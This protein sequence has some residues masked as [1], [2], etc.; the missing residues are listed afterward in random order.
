M[1]PEALAQVLR[2]LPRLNSDDLLIGYDTSDDACVYRISDTQAMIQTVDFFPPMVDDPYL[3]G[4]IAAANALSDV[5]AMGGQPVLA[6]NLLCFP[7]CL[8]PTIAGQ[9][10]AGG[11]NK[12]AEAGCVIAGGHSIQ[13]NEPKYGLCVSGF[14]HPDHILANSAA[15]PGDRLIVTKALGT[16]ILTTAQKG[17]LLDEG[18]FAAAV[19]SMRTLNK[20]AAQ[21]ASGL[22]VHACTDI[23]GFGLAGHLCEMA[24]GS[25]VSARL[26]ASRVPLLPQARQ[27]AEMGMIPSGAYRNRD[28]FQ[29]RVSL[30]ADVS[31][32]IADLLFDPQTSGGLLFSVEEDQAP[33]LLDRL[34]L[35]GVTAEQIG[36]IMAFNGTAVHID[37]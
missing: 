27:M 1:A 7:S 33:I 31:E 20:Y 34:R 18:V 4:Q 19:E 9:I 2:K 37:A 12:A 36:E 24:E 26:S 17:G 5:Y 28:Y 22:A 10:L 8:D 25:G 32:A 14:V 29:C 11:A 15:Q 30:A 23:T 21:A 3:F 16:G 35:A 13:D 6:M